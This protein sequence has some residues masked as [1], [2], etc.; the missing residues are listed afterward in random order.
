[1]E[2][3]LI[4]FSVDVQVGFSLLWPR[5]RVRSD[6]Q[7]ETSYCQAQVSQ[8]DSVAPVHVQPH[9]RRYKVD[10]LVGLL[11]VRC[12]ESE[13]PHAVTIYMLEPQICQYVL[14]VSSRRLKE[15]LH[16]TVVK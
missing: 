10:S 1:M 9:V 15:P 7:A 12:K 2:I 6:R 11:S 14:G 13:S 4:F 16:N 3:L 5:G 8:Y